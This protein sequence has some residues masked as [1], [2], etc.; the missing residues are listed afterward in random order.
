MMKNGTNSHSFFEEENGFAAV[1]HSEIILF[2]VISHYT[3]IMLV[4]SWS[5]AADISFYS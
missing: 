1:A 3:V 4:S 2:H 5:T